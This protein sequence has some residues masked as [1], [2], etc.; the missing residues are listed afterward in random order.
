MNKT[1][2]K[3]LNR[4]IHESIQALDQRGIDTLE[5][6]DLSEFHQYLEETDNTICGRHPIAVLMASLQTIAQEEVF[7][8]QTVKCIK[9]A[10]SSPCKRYEDSSV[11]Y[12]SIYIQIN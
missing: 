11:S 12:A 2:A 8:H 10:Q 6:L 5:A 4:P 3:K 7:S 9:Y 1:N